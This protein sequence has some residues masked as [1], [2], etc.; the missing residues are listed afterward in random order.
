MTR[1]CHANLSTSPI[2]A[3]WFVIDVR[4]FRLDLFRLKY[5]VIPWDLVEQVAI[6]NVSWNTHILS[7]IS[8]HS[9]FAAGL[10]G[11]RGSMSLM[12]NVGTA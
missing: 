6:E 2:P 4:H 7:C 9:R 11:S 1:N 10:S 12:R 3:A 8:L 5:R